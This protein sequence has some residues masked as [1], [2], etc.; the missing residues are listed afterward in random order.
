MTVITVIFLSGS[1]VRRSL[2]I[3][4]TAS[5]PRCSHIIHNT[6]KQPSVFHFISAD[7]FN[8]IQAYNLYFRFI[9][10]AN[11]ARHHKFDFAIACPKISRI[12]AIIS[13]DIA[14]FPCSVF[15]ITGCLIAFRIKIDDHRRTASCPGIASFV[16][17]H[18][19]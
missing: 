5:V 10:P 2:S 15:R 7:Y 9:H 3:I 14:G 6:V 11:N 4:Q 12:C 17:N 18:S 16:F 1:Q 13:V 8:R 19:I